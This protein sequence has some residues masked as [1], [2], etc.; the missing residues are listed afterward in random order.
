MTRVSSS[1]PGKVVL[2]GEYVVLDGAPAVSMAVNRRAVVTLDAAD[3]L[4]VRS[5]GLDGSTDLRLFDN[6]RHAL[7][8]DKWCGAACLDTRAFSDANAGIKYG[9]GSSAALAVALAQALA[10]PGMDDDLSLIHI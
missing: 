7:R 8:S 3:E 4:S 10:P 9:I 2:A 6:V 5:K 1:A